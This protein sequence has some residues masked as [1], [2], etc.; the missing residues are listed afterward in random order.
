MSGLER[1]EERIQYDLAN[2]NDSSPSKQVQAIRSLSRVLTSNWFH[3]EDEEVQQKVAETFPIFKDKILSENNQKVKE[4][5]VEFFGKLT[6]LE[7]SYNFL[8]ELFFSA[9]DP[10]SYHA[11]DAM[12]NFTAKQDKTKALF[13]DI[14]R[15]SSSEFLR[16]TAIGVLGNRFQRLYPEEIIPIIKKIAREDKSTKVR[17]LAWKRFEQIASNQEVLQESAKIREEALYT[18][19]FEILSLFRPDIPVSIS[20]IIE[21]SKN[22]AVEKAKETLEKVQPKQ[23][24]FSSEY[25]EGKISEIIELKALSGEYLPLEQ[26][27]IRSSDTETP[28]MKPIAISKEYICYY[29]GYPI[30]KDSKT[31]SS[32]NIVV[33]SCMV[34]KLPISF[35]E[36]PGKCR[37]CEGASHLS[38]LQEWVKVKGKCPTCL[39]ELTVEGI[40]Q[41]TLKFTE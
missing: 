28:L 4:A 17:G 5:I 36:E 20:R 7:E 14:L 2:S 25:F 26:V 33:L 35:G 34:C 40:D 22:L 19:L 11:A 41:V 18:A 30:E 10:L 31:C 13:L 6:F 8:L 23:F 24:D 3:M 29:C 15:E 39:K 16:Y 38:H 1:L 21:L 27:F 12:T 32:C 9:E 37:F